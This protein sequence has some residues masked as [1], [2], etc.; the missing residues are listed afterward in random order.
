[1]FFGVRKPYPKYPRSLGMQLDKW[2]I[3]YGNRIAVTDSEEEIT[4]SE[5]NQKAI[6]TG[7]YFMEKGIQKGDKVLVQLPN[8]ISFVVVLFALAKIGAVPIMMLPAHR[9]TELEGIIALAKPSAYIVAERYLGFYYVEMA[10][11]MQK[12]FP[13]IQNVFVD[14]TQRGA[15]YEAETER[16]GVFPEVDSY[17]T[18]VLLLSGGTTG[19][20]KLI[21]RTHTDYMYNARMSAKRCQLDESSVYLAAL[22]VAHNFPLCCP[23]LLGTFDIG[24]KVV[25]APTTSPDDILTA[26]TEEKVTITALVPAMVTVCMEMLEYDEDYDISSLKILQVGGAMLEDSLADKI[27]EEWPCTLMQVFGTAEGLLSFTSPDDDVTVIARCQGTPVSPADEVKIVDE[28]DE[29][30]PTGVFGELLSRGPYTID[31]YY[32]AEET[33]RTSFTEDGVVPERLQEAWSRIQYHHPMLRAS[34]SENG[35]QK[36]ESKPYSE[37]IKINDFSLLTETEAEQEA[38][39]VRRR[40]SHRK[41]KI[42]EGEVAGLE[43]TLLPGNKTRLHIDLDLL[44]ADVQSLQILL[45]DLAMVYSGVELPEESKDWNFAAYLEQQNVEDREE[46]KK[47]KEYWSARLKNL[48]QG[49]DMPLA[50]RPEEVKNPVFHRRVVRIGKEEW[51]C[52]QRRAKEYQT[53]P[54]MLLLTAYSAILERWSKNKSFLINIPFFNR[55]TEYKGLE[56]VIADFTT[57]LLLEI[58]CEGNPTFLELLDRIQKQLH[59]DMKYTTYSGVQVQRDLTQMYGDISAIAPIVFACNLGTELVNST[60]TENF[61]SFSYMISQTPQ[62]WNDFQSYEDENGVQLTWDTIDELFPED[63]IDDMLTSFEQLLHNLR[64]EDWNQ[65]FDV[66][67]ERQ[68]NFVRKECTIPAASEQKVLFQEFFENVERSPERIAIIDTGKELEISYSRLKEMAQRVAAGIIKRNIKEESIAITIPRGYEQIV[69]V[70]AVLISGNVY[71]PVSCEQPSERRKLIHEK[72]DI[73]YVITT[74]EKEKQIEWPEN[75]EIWCVEKL[76][77]NELLENYPK[78]YPEDSAY[79]IMTSGST[80]Q[81][82]G[83]EMSHANAWNTIEYINRKYCV[84]QTDAILAVSALDFDLSVYDQFGLLSAGGKIILIPESES[85]NPDYWLKMIFEYHITRW[86]SVPIL[87]EMLFECWKA[88]KKEKI[89]FRTAFYSGDWTLLYMVDMFYEAVEDGTLIVLGGTTETGI[90]SNEQIVKLPLPEN[91]KTIPYGRPLENQAYRVVD[92]FGRDCP[93]WVEGELWIGGEG[94][95]KGYRGD[96]VLT[97]QK[98]I[99][100][101]FGRWYRT[102]DNGCFWNDGTI[103]YRGRRDFQVKVKGH[104]IE[105][106]EIE[107]ILNKIAGVKK[108]IVCAVEHNNRKNML[109]AVVVKESPNI[110]EEFLMQNLKSKLP[111]YMLPTKIIFEDKLPVGKNAKQDRKEVVRW[112]KAHEDRNIENEEKLTPCETRMLKIWKRLLGNDNITKKDNYFVCGGDSLL[113]VRMTAEIEAEFGVKVSIGIIF[114]NNTVES[115]AKRISSIKEKRKPNIE[116]VQHNEQERFQEFLTTEM[117]YAYWIGRQNVYALGNVS[118][119]CY[120]EIVSKNLSIERLERAWNELIIENDALRL[121]FSKDGKRQKVLESVPYYNLKVYNTDLDGKETVES[122]RDDMSQQIMEASQWPLFDIRVSICQDKNIVHVGI[123]NL[124]MDA[125]SVLSILYQWTQRYVG[126]NKS[127]LESVSFRDYVCAMNERN[128]LLIVTGEVQ[129]DH[130]SCMEFPYIKENINLIIEGI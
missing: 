44:I 35:M 3:R 57:L 10:M 45:R 129:G 42:E 70:L 79:I 124:I 31:G 6:G 110:N 46:R 75:V 108:S 77:E 74:A 19:V 105:L 128:M 12:K 53:T 48:P 94:V 43:L 112:I 34:F 115:L 84:D 78:I 91:W 23:G 49:P 47:A 29:E 26:I 64:K 16:Q 13:C 114:E 36:I 55:K 121:V 11:A 80:G 39:A 127:K 37:K 20:P 72:T 8:R 92:D 123:D 50:K 32:M 21:P 68:K 87:G 67:P 4:Y 58:N 107:A 104:R 73:H 54:A 2:A 122:I 93:F 61:G 25:L 98:Y 60:F 18:A 27:I 126:N 102:G 89:P 101:C 28:N 62:V 59:E 51:D 33:N 85:K 97:K 15:W 82:K 118:S 117:Q 119:Y 17:S 66:L 100:D 24:G 88:Q 125:R 113:A 1:M 106:G 96:E 65:R 71:V 52:L 116:V 103:E 81:P 7:Q 9:E 38:Q 90:W 95:G 120:Y 14:G 69:A 30:V 41:L 83:V 56:D 63:M 76:L 99:M 130:I 111:V 109:V 22:P 5:L 86:N 40:L